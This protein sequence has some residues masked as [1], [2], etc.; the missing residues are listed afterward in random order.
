MKRKVILLFLFTCAYAF[1]FAQGYEPLLR[2]LPKRTSFDQVQK[3][4]NRYYDSV[5][6][7]RGTGYKQWK[8][9]EWWAL[10]HLAPEGFVEDNIGKNKEALQRISQSS[11]LNT[12]GTHGSWVAMGPTSVNNGNDDVGRVVCIAFH[13]SNANTFYV[14][15]PA[16]G[17]W[18][19]TNNGASFVSLTDHLPGLG[20]ASIAI[21][22][23]NPNIIYILTGD[24]NASHRGHYLKEHGTGVYRTT[25]GGET[26]QETAMIW[27]YSS[28]TFGYKL[29]MHPS[30]PN[31]L[32]AAT[33]S[34]F[35][36][37]FNSGATWTQE[38]ATEEITDI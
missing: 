8:R 16:G 11:Q 7:A 20:V 12:P 1:V 10:R 4:V 13:P 28:V 37:S 17:L 22:P 38:L 15:T 9:E 27:D 24:G 21:H 23:T 35:W 6:Q 14:G 18:R 30:D 26:W 32:F 25:D 19:T 36:R 34:G 31:I 2:D 29:V 33:S 3:I 5:G